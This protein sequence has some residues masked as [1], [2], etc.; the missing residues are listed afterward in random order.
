VAREREP[1][2]N[3]SLFASFSSEKE[4][5]LLSYPMRGLAFAA[6]VV[7]LVG[8]IL[9][10]CNRGPDP[11]DEGIVLVG[12]DMVAHGAVPHRDFYANYG[13]AQFAVLA[14]LFK[15][16]GASVL[17]ERVWDA[18]VKA[19]IV[20]FTYGVTRGSSG[21]VVALAAA[22]T[23]VFWLLSFGI[24][25]GYPLFPAA[26]ACV[27]AVWFLLWDWPPCCVV[28][29]GAAGAAAGLAALFRPD[30]GVAAL[31]AGIG[32]IG[33]CHWLAGGPDWRWVRAG[34]R[35]AL[36]FAAGWLAV[37]VPLLVCW[38]INGAWPGVIFGLFTYP[39]TV[40]IRARSMPFPDWAA[41]EKY[42]QFISVYVPPLV[43][44]CTVPA[45]ARVAFARVRGV[46]A[47]DLAR[48]AGQSALLLLFAV[49]GWMKGVVRASDLHTVMG[50]VFCVPLIPRLWQMGSVMPWRTL[51]RGAVVCACAMLVLAGLGARDEW[52]RGYWNLR[53]LNNPI[54][55]GWNYWAQRS[56]SC[57]PPPWLR[58]FACVYVDKDTIDT[59]HYIE[60]HGHRGDFLFV[61]L[62]RHDKIFANDIMLYFAAER[63]PA[64]GWYH[65]DPGLQNTDA[66]QRKIIASLQRTQP[67]L[68]VIHS[69]FQAFDEPNLSSVSSGVT[70]LD[71][72]L[73]STYTPVAT[74]GAFVI[75]APN[76]PKPRA[77]T[78]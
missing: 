13:P 36:I 35:A 34:L 51:R 32:G 73:K 28:R 49:L 76:Q 61:A 12:A 43:F 38:S 4:E 67:K 27:V 66:V 18:L 30:I 50:F 42:P 5:S 29:L 72:Y 69:I 62:P 65:F 14:W 71:D 68:L 58:R 46:L 8:L 6:L 22:A 17:V 52:H 59:V 77:T 10:T 64:T 2:L 47:P 15:M 41:I 16:F 11:Y 40:Y 75:L 9:L 57:V 60:S 33:Y 23:S 55:W 20:L 19:L 26:A 53:W 44:A 54:A 31:L 37:I 70:V 63:L 7:L 74:F 48:A 25:Y 45:L 24:G 21:R 78:E 56:G 39:S 3:K 1:P